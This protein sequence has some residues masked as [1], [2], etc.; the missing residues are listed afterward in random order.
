MSGGLKNAKKGTLIFQ[1]IV[2]GKKE[3]AALILLTSFIVVIIWKLRVKG[4]AVLEC[5]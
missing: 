3:R 1:G 4:T 2:P 5:R